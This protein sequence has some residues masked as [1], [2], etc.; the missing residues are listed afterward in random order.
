[1]NPAIEVQGLRYAWPGQPPLL[2]L[3]E[4]RIARG[5]KL[6]LHGPS[7]SGK[8]TLLA[9]LGG[10]RQADAGVLR[11]LGTSLAALGG[12]RR[13][14]FRADHIGFVFQLFNLLPYLDVRGNVLLPCR[15]SRSRA[16]RARARHGSLPAHADALLEALDLPAALRT[17]RV[18]ALS[19]GQQQRV[20]VARALA[21]APELVIC[22]EPTSALDTDTR[23]RFIDLLFQC[24][25]EAGSTLV[26]VSHDRDLAARFDR[27][28]GLTDLNQAGATRTSP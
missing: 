16:A 27:T 2:D 22:D 3:P 17:R 7:G 23:Q 25:H 11:I 15:F 19:V 20:A 8:S 9:L 26:F 18:D 10:V 28:L 21:G 14:R 6:F 4:L 1:M 5:E 13:D 24:V 12:A